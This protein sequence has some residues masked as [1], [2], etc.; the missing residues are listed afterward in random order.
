MRIT[1]L[2]GRSVTLAE[3]SKITLQGSLMICQLTS[4]GENGKPELVARPF[5]NEE[6]CEQFFREV[7]CTTPADG[8]INLENTNFDPRLGA[9]FAEFDALFDD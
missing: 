4:P 9:M 3:V 5:P 2:E 1:Y 7:V 8:I 6:I